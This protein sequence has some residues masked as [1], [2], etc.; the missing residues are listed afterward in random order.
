[1]TETSLKLLTLPQDTGSGGKSITPRKCLSR[2]CFIAAVIAALVGTIFIGAQ[3]VGYIQWERL[4][5][6]VLYGSI[7]GGAVGLS[8]ASFALSCIREKNRENKIERETLNEDESFLEVS[9]PVE[10]EILLDTGEVIAPYQYEAGEALYAAMEVFK[11]Y[12]HAL[13]EKFGENN[14]YRTEAKKFIS[15]ILEGYTGEELFQQKVGLFLE[16]FD[17]F[18][19]WQQ[20]TQLV[21]WLKEVALEI[22]KKSEKKGWP[23]QASFYERQDQLVRSF[24]SWQRQLVPD[25]KPLYRKSLKLEFSQP[26][27]ETL[28]DFSELTEVNFSILSVSQTDDLGNIEPKESRK[29]HGKKPCRT[30]DFSNLEAFEDELQEF[31]VWY[32]YAHQLFL[33]EQCS[34]AYFTTLQ[35]LVD[36]P[37]VSDLDISKIVERNLRDFSDKIVQTT[38][39]LSSLYLIERKYVFDSSLFLS[40]LKAID[41]IQAIA[42][43]TSNFQG[44]A[45]STKWFGYALK[46]PYFDSGSYGSEIFKTIQSLESQR[47]VKNNQFNLVTFETF[48]WECGREDRL[49]IRSD[50]MR[51]YSNKNYFKGRNESFLIYDKKLDEAVINLRAIYSLFNAL[52]YPVFQ[53][54]NA[55]KR[56]YYSQTPEDYISAWKDLKQKFFKAADLVEK[57]KMLIHVKGVDALNT[58]QT[59]KIEP[60]EGFLDYSSLAFGAGP[61][62]VTKYHGLTFSPFFGLDRS[63]V[64]VDLRNRIVEGVVST[65]TDPG[66][67]EYGDGYKTEFEQ[68]IYCY[69]PVGFKQSQRTI[70]GDKF[71]FKSLTLETS[72]E[73]QFMASA[74]SNKILNTLYTFKNNFFLLSGENKTY[75][76]RIFRLNLFR[77]ILFYKTALTYPENFSNLYVAFREIMDGFKEKDWETWL[78]LYK[79]QVDLY[80]QLRGNE[81]LQLCSFEHDFIQ[82]N[83]LIAEQILS[84]ESLNQA[85]PTRRYFHLA[86]LYH[87]SALGYK[88]DEL[89]EIGKSYFLLK[90]WIERL[91]FREKIFLKNLAHK[92]LPEIK[93][94]ILRE[95]S[96]LDDFIACRIT[97]VTTDS[98]W[99]IEGSV[100]RKGGFTINLDNLGFVYH[101]SME[102]LLPK[103][104]RHNEKLKMLF[105]EQVLGKV[106]QF[107][108][109]KIK[110]NEFFRTTFSIQSTFYFLLYMPSNEDYLLLFRQLENGEKIE[111]LHFPEVQEN[112]GLWDW[113]EAYLWYAETNVKVEDANGNLLYI[114]EESGKVSKIIQDVPVALLNPSSVQHNALL[115]EMGGKDSYAVT[116]EEQPRV[117]YRDS[118]LSYKWDPEK[119]Q[120]ESE[121]FKGFYLSSKNLETW[122]NPTCFVNQAIKGKQT[123]FFT[124][125]FT[126]YHLLESNSGEAKLILARKPFDKLSY[127]FSNDPKYKKSCET[128][129]STTPSHKNNGLAIFEIQNGLKSKDPDDYFFLAYVFFT[130]AKYDQALYYLKRSK[131]LWTG[132]HPHANDFQKRMKRWFFEWYELHD[133]SAQ[134]TALL[135]H[136]TLLEIKILQQSSSDVPQLIVNISAM[137]SQV[138]ELKNTYQLKLNEIDIQMRLSQ[139]DLEDLNSFFSLAQ[140]ISAHKEDEKKLEQ[141][142]NDHLDQEITEYEKKILSQ[143][144]RGNKEFIQNQPKPYISKPLLDLSNWFE[145]KRVENDQNSFDLY[146]K[147]IRKVKSIF[148]S[149]KKQKETKISSALIADIEKFISSQESEQILAPQCD[150]NLLKETLEKEEKFYLK[151]ERKSK[152]TSLC[153]FILPTVERKQEIERQLKENETVLDY[154]LKMAVVSF[155]RNDFQEMINSQYLPKEKT[156]NIKASISSYLVARTNRQLISRKIEAVKR[157]LNDPN[158]EDL[159]LE[160]SRDLLQEREY[161]V[162]THP[163]ANLL[164]AFEE[165]ENISLRKNQVEHINKLLL[166][167]NAFLHEQ[168]A[169]GKTSVIR[170]VISAIQSDQDLLGGVMTY[171]PLM[172]THH[173]DYSHVN[174]KIFWKDVVPF[175]FS[176]E[177][178]KDPIVIKRFIIQILKLFTQKGL[179]DQTVSSCLSLKHSLTELVASLKESDQTTLDKLTPSI[180][181][182]QKLIRLRAQYLSLYSDEIDKI[183]DPTKEINYSYGKKSVL[184]KKFYGPALEILKVLLKEPDLERLKDSFKS[185]VAHSLSHSE[186]KMCIENLTRKLLANWKNFPLDIEATVIYLSGAYQQ[187]EKMTQETVDFYKDK[188]LTLKDGELRFQL[189]TLHA[190][191]AVLM[192]GMQTE[193][194]KKSI[195]VSFG[196]SKNNQIDVKPFAFSAKSQENS[197]RSFIL[198]TV[199]ETCLD[200]ACDKVSQKGVELYLERFKQRITKEKKNVDKYEETKA[201]IDFKTKFGFP[202]QMLTPE[203]IQEVREKINGNPELLSEVLEEIVFKQFTYYEEK[204]EGHSHQ[205]PYLVNSISGASGSPE[206][207]NTLPKAINKEN[208]NLAWQQGAVG[209]VLYNLFKDFD[210]QID[211]IHLKTDIAI[212]HQLVS[213]LQLGDTLIDNAPFFPG[214][215]GEQIAHKLESAWGRENIYFRILDENENVVLWSRRTGVFQ[216][217]KIDPALMINI[218]DHKGRQGT[219]WKFARNTNGFLEIDETTNFTDFTQS[220]MR[221]R[222]LGKGQKAKLLL[223]PKLQES[224]NQIPELA[225]A[226]IA[227]KILWTLIKNESDCVKPLNMRAN[228]KTIKTIKTEFIDSLITKLQPAT[229]KKCIE[230]PAFDMLSQTKLNAIEYGLPIQLVNPS[231]QLDKKIDSVSDWLDKISVWFFQ[232]SFGENEDSVFKGALEIAKEKLADQALKLPGEELPDQ[233]PHTELDLDGIEEIEVEQESIQ[234]EEVLAEVEQ[235]KELELIIENEIDCEDELEVE[236]ESRYEKHPSSELGSEWMMNIDLYADLSE[237]SIRSL[238]K[239]GA[240]KGVECISEFENFWV[241]IPY[242]KSTLWPFSGK[243]SRPQP[244]FTPQ[245]I[246][247]VDKNNHQSSIVYGT[248]KFADLFIDLCIKKIKKWHSDFPYEIYKIDLR[249]S[250]WPEK[251]ENLEMAKNQLA[252]AKLLY[253]DAE[254]SQK[255]IDFLKSWLKNNSIQKNRLIDLLKQV[256]PNTVATHPALKLFEP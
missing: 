99:E 120:W 212:E 25:F 124:T 188:I 101:N 6:I 165:E 161:C 195:G 199:L 157:L 143:T 40:F 209:S 72:R 66:C 19:N 123:Y 144:Q 82:N 119:K 94:H 117:I 52:L 23:L 90:E 180:Q 125:R 17:E 253:L 138:E 210:S 149:K 41:W 249:Q 45:I 181:A 208:P 68:K 80:A 174:E 226:H 222:L 179:I 140:K 21:T 43:Q 84:I 12:N 27:Q 146:F 230:N 73:V 35:L 81:I 28:I 244:M 204:I 247:F 245:V 135:T 78:F 116:D 96:R 200:Y 142:L 240:I 91:N 93:D 155:S 151:Q 89:F 251:I 148:E 54:K 217:T 177:T 92:L 228:A 186:F 61:T 53:F 110:N 11:S 86:K 98:K 242:S 250:K 10:P 75:Y 233:V 189:Q 218:I 102:T 18:P 106:H 237:K 236:V 113:N 132:V 95:P 76:R 205:I 4:T 37:C 57:N 182:L 108:I 118:H 24:S 160:C 201:A 46:D 63:I 176:R 112:Y 173:K 168:M 60:I 65:A 126:H 44:Y 7:Y 122:L 3:V 34:E 39:L 128:T 170:N 14:V 115:A 232:Q 111:Q 196:R 243:K 121:Q 32:D 162:Q 166:H 175:Y 33:D 87:A 206:R 193:H 137:L 164:L 51:Y 130:Q 238:F 129:F 202:I 55:L 30:P 104:I 2:V 136:L 9:D 252:F 36:L 22:Q 190:Y 198:A 223:H 154:F 58:Y 109:V 31:Q 134:A 74:P 254:F 197:Q 220:L 239:K 150:L 234:I 15:K 131:A 156:E 191:L 50:E 56:D 172:E 246:M 178:S 67:N 214:L 224:W 62:Y 194:Q 48:D 29:I 133:S 83:R 256:Y 1:M 79:V 13:I 47:I 207:K 88:T 71:V 192:R 100:C 225:D 5:S 152:A 183:F 69:C 114:I 167:R 64:E 42:Q 97:L 147:E 8:F 213:H 211:L 153:C 187:N 203:R 229:L 255:E 169:G 49:T 216:N 159:R 105:G 184:E 158:N 231:L 248:I 107:D 38:Y 103:S 185:D 85:D 26:P 141:I 227:T 215:T 145:S 139:C 20:E 70:E 219:D 16:L 127:L 241:T 59:L 235:D 221:L 171:N 163:Y 77:D